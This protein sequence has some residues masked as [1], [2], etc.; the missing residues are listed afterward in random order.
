M[1]AIERGEGGSEAV[2][3][4]WL[5]K[6]IG[7]PRGPQWICDTCGTVHSDWLPVC[8]SCEA[9]DSLSWKSAPVGSVPTTMSA[10]MLP[11]LTGQRTETVHEDVPAVLADDVALVEA[12]EGDAD[13]LSDA[14]RPADRTVAPPSRPID[15]SIVGTTDDIDQTSGEAR[16]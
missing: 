9:F 6:A 16:R 1:A 11:L 13:V 8:T 14:E 2:V 15:P 12:T 4:G 7:A 10:E 3:R 5:A